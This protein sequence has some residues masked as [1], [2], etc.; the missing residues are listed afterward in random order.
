MKTMKT[1]RSL[2]PLLALV[3]SL[4]VSGVASAHESHNDAKAPAGK[5]VPITEKDAAWA[6]KAKA[7]YPVTACV[8]SD[9]KLEDGDMG[10]PVDYIYRQEGKPDRLIRFCCKDC[11][12]DFN[13]NPAKYLKTLDDA[14]AKKGKGTT[15]G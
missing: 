11:L 10:K 2:P 14:Q 5:L 4:L 15:K 7:E 8:V 6:A 3:A 12:K 1:I 13:E 9:D